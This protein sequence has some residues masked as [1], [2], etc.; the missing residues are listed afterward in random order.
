MKRLRRKKRRSA[1]RSPCIPHDTLISSD[2]F[3]NDE[4][5]P[6]WKGVRQ[7]E[8]DGRFGKPFLGRLFFKDYVARTFNIPNTADQITVMFDVYEIDD[9]NGGEIVISINDHKIRVGPFWEDIDEGLQ[10]GYVESGAITWSMI[11]WWKPKNLGFGLEKDQKHKFIAH[12]P[13]AFPRVRLKVEN[14]SP[15]GALGIQKVR[16]NGITTCSRDESFS[17]FRDS[18]ERRMEARVMIKAYQSFFMEDHCWRGVFPRVDINL[19]EKRSWQEADP[20]C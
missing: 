16:T 13:R 12:M 8:Q 3:D 5:H 2:V 4:P 15:S 11:S 20:R 9:F 1:R 17:E 6:D 18:A 14:L 19:S 7:T 10:S